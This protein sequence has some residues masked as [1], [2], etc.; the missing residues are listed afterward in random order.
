MITRLARGLAIAGALFYGSSASAKVIRTY[1]NEVVYGNSTVD[2]LA[3]G[4]DV[5]AGYHS[6]AWLSNGLTTI[7]TDTSIAGATGVDAAGVG[8]YFNGADVNKLCSVGQFSVVFSML[9]L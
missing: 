9:L 1:G 3:I 4:F 6:P 7:N 5:H 8:I 2:S